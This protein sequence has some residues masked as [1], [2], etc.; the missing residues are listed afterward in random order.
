[1]D[2]VGLRIKASRVRDVS[3]W[4]ASTGSSAQSEDYIGKAQASGTEA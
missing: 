1:M 2:F 4:Y 3:H